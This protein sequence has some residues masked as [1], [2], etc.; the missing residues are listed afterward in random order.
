MNRA[1]GFSRRL[2]LLLPLCGAA[3]LSS[4]IKDEA[5][6]AECDIEQAAIRVANPADYFRFLTDTVKNVASL[7]SVITFKVRYQAD[8]TNLAPVFKLT[9][10][11][12]I[13]PQNG[14]AHDFSFAKGGV[15]Y[16]VTSED[17]A[18]H[19]RYH[20]NCYPDTIIVNDTIHYDFEQSALEPNGRYYLWYET[21]MDGKPDYVWATGN[22]GF[23]LSKSSAKPMEYPTVPEESG[24]EGNAV[25]LTTQSTG[26]FGVMVNMRIAAGNLFLGTFDASYALKDAMQATC[27]GAPFNKKPKKLTGYYKYTPGATY[28]DKLGN[29]VA[30]KTDAPDIYAVLYKNHDANGN[31]I[32]LHGD[33]VL[34]NPNIVALA[35]ITN[36]GAPTSWTKFDLNFD[37]SSEVDEK[38]LAAQGY[39]LAVVFSSSIDGAT[40]CGAV[41][42]TLLIDKVQLICTSEK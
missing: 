39:S 17:G 20:V 11:A 10:G 36:P 19:R 14:S 5:P 12:T 28:Q 13:D 25:K 7:D 24:L 32:V 27:F 41:G 26:G 2:F 38:I 34:S 18:W 31:S 3:C 23:K 21:G 37:Y 42:S 9:E 6:N 16:T 35:R 29:A 8:L 30:G 33:D 4:C 22:P 15:Y 1:Q 40:F